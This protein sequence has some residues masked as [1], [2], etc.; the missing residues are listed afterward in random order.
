MYVTII[1]IGG[2]VLSAKWFQET[3]FTV[4]HILIY[5]IF[6]NSEKNTDT[7]MQFGKVLQNNM[8]R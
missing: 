8:S 7:T 2:L 5:V 1:V 6:N 4:I 3:V